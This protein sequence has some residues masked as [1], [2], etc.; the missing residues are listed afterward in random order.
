MPMATRPVIYP[1]SD[2]TI[3]VAIHCH[4]STPPSVQF[5]CFPSREHLDLCFYVLLAAYGL[6]QLSNSRFLFGKPGGKWFD[7]EVL[8][9]DNPTDFWRPWDGETAQRQF[10]PKLVFSER[11][12]LFTLGL[13]GVGFFPE[14][15]KLWFDIVASLHALVWEMALQFGRMS[16]PTGYRGLAVVWHSLAKMLHGEP[17]RKSI[18]HSDRDLALVLAGLGYELA[19]RATPPFQIDFCE[20]ARIHLMNSRWWADSPPTALPL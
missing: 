14:P 1:S 10:R 9:N 13:K 19:E 17:P 11:K 2:Q 16:N 20:Y 5:L 6:R 15:V 8:F 18:K 12:L 7:E 4:S 3:E